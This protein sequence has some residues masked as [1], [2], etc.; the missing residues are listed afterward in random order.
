MLAVQP[1]GK[2]AYAHSVSEGEAQHG[3]IEPVAVRV[4]DGSLLGDGPAVAAAFASFLAY[5]RL[6]AAAPALSAVMQKRQGL[7][8]YLSRHVALAE[9][10]AL[11]EWFSGFEASAGPW[12]ALPLSPYS[13]IV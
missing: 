9:G 3:Y 13:I 10:P 11:D 4:E 5:R 6:L 7:E 1:G 12:C 8:I 2:R